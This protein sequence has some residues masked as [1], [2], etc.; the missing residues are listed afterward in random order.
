[1]FDIPGKVATMHKVLEKQEQIPKQG[2]DA[3]TNCIKS[4]QNI[5]VKGEKKFMLIEDI[6]FLHFRLLQIIV[7]SRN[8]S[9]L[10]T[11]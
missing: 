4:I 11:A 9:V 1:M 3:T 2:T 6:S 8:K 10:M 7:S 5:T